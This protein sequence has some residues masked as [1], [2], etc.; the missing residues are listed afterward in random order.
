MTPISA[1][2]QNLNKILFRK[3]KMWENLNNNK[4]GYIAPL[5]LQNEKLCLKVYSFLSFYFYRNIEISKIIDN[6]TF[7]RLGKNLDYMISIA[8]VIRVL[9]KTS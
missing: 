1:W 2:L 4:K 9:I 5:Y 3:K 8:L 7:C 6:S